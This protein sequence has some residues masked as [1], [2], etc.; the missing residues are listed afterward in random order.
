ARWLAGGVRPDG[1]FRYFVDAP[2]N[3]TLSGYD[4]PR[5]AGATYF[6]AQ[7]AAMAKDREIAYAA[8]LAARHLR[9]KAMGPCGDAKG[10]RSDSIVDV[11]S[12]ALALIAFVEIHRAKFD[13]SYYDIIAPLARFLRNQQRPDGEFM[14]Q[15][16][17]DSGKPIDIQLLYFSGE[18]TLALSGAA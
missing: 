16:D 1:K 15:F 9:E 7:A 11:G 5:H 6:L 2:S 18:A 10:I 14:H 8:L 4:W 12:T 17:R 3:R 13:L